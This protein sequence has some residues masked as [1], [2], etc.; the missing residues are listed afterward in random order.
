MGE[1]IIISLSLRIEVMKS[2]HAA[3]RPQLTLRL[4]INRILASGRITRADEKFFFKV[5]AT[6]T[7]LS[8]EELDMVTRV[9]DRFQMGLIKLAD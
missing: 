5:L 6:E 9:L 3:P 8:S 1:S 7:T 2:V 4:I